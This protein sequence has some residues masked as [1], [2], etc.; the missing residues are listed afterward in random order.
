[1]KTFFISLF[2]IASTISTMVSQETEKM[3]GTFN[4]YEDG[5]FSFTDT[6][7]YSIEFHHISDVAKATIDLSQ[8]K[9]KGKLFQITFIGETE[10]DDQ[11]EEITVNRI[12]A[13]K[14]VE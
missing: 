13:L 11:N 4:G 7:G 1:M 6:D 12:T 2:L 10:M 8:E 14:V 3:K 9:F 5:I